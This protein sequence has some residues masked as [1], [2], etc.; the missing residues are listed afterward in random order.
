MLHHL[1]CILFD[2]KYKLNYFSYLNFMMRLITTDC[3]EKNSMDME[4]Y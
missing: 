4:K 3:G 1:L 2:I